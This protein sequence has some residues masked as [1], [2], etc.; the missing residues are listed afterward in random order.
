MHLPKGSLL[1]GH[2]PSHSLI[3]GLTLWY[4]RGCEQKLWKVACALPSSLFS[5][6]QD[7]CMYLPGCI[8]KVQWIVWFKQEEWL[9][10]TGWRLEIRVSAWFLH[11]FV[12]MCPMPLPWLLAAHWHPSAFLGLTVY[13]FSL[14]LYVHVVFSLCESLSLCPNVPLAWGHQSFG[15]KAHSHDLTLIWS[16]TKILFS[17]EV[18]F[19]DTDGLLFSH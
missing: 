14:F 6:H 2:Y 13:H 9:H 7:Q 11:R 15:I 12:S 5:L 17:D 4:P 8:S 18:I 3:S 10:L 16:T 1:C 19:T